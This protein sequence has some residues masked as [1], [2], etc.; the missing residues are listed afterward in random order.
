[1]K[2]IFILTILSLFLISCSE[3]EKSCN[4]KCGRVISTLVYTN[5]PM[6]G[7]EVYEI[8]ILTDCNDVIYKNIPFNMSNGF[9]GEY[10]YST[11]R[12][13]IGDALCVD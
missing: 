13:E 10:P 4:P 12:Y 2:K 7:D 5:L 1:M 8:T 6:N 11:P 3:N 9:P